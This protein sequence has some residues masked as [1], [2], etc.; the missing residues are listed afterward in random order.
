LHSINR[1][2][3]TRN[4]Q[5]HSERIIPNDIKLKINEYLHSILN[6]K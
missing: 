4:K 1:W 5:S 2:Y 3:L 6:E